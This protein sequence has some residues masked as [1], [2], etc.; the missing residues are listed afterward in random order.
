MI[1]PLVLGRGKWLFTN[2]SYPTNLKLASTHT[3]STGLLILTYQ[4]DTEQL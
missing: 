2:A 4:P 3:T 1:H